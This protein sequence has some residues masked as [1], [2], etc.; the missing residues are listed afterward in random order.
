MSLR[1]ARS[2]LVELLSEAAGTN[3]DPADFGSVDV[4]RAFDRGMLEGIRVAIEVVDDV[5]S[6]K[7]RECPPN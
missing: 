2:I 3:S 1:L 5:I 4:A 6:L 7:G